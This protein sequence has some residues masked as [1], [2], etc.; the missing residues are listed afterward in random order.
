MWVPSHDRTEVSGDARADRA[1]QAVQRLGTVMKVCSDG[2]DM[3]GSAAG[4]YMAVTLRWTSV[5]VDTTSKRATKAHD[6][7]KQDPRPEQ[8]REQQHGLVQNAAPA[9]EPAAMAAS[10][11][12]LD[13]V[14]MW[15]ETGALRS[16]EELLR[17][18]CWPYGCV[19]YH[20]KET[21]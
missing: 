8:Y 20:W 7:K 18:C 3:L 15:T 11:R 21:R 5:V 12:L 10:H 9:D 4:G 14:N 13:V 2:I 19:T 17:V 1:V 16:P 6:L